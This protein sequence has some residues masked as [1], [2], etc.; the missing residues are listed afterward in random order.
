M[1]EGRFRQDLFY[2]LS[3]F[4]IVLPPLRE[5]P[6]DIPALAESFLERFGRENRRTPPHL[7]REALKRLQ[8]YPWPGNVRELFNVLERAAILSTGR[9]LDLGAAL[10]EGRTRA[11]ALPTWEQQ[12]R[13]YLSELMRTCRGRVTGAEGAAGRAGLAPSTLLSR[14]ERLGLRPSAFRT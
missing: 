8:A 1:A 12:E 10:P 3:V 11:E 4:P 9:E 7:G 13:T 14:L 6:E 5:R 2:R